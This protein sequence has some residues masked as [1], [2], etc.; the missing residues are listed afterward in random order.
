MITSRPQAMA[1]KS[2]QTLRDEA[3]SLIGQYLLQGYRMLA[4]H[5]GDCSV[6]Y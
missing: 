6:S 5:C 2:R 4:Q 1:D 3:S